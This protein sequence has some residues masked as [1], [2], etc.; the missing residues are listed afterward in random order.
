[1]YNVNRI[2]RNAP[3]TC[4][5]NLTVFELISIY[6]PN[7]LNDTQTDTQSDENSIS[8]NSL[9]SLSGYNKHILY[10]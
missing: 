8:V 7:C 5:L 10:Y 3:Q 6:R 2:T 4:A 9:P 1:M